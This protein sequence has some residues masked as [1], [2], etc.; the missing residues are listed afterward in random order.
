MAA[1]RDAVPADPAPDAAGAPD[2]P[3]ARDRPA[4]PLLRVRDLEAAYGGAIV[5]LHGVS[6]DVAA[7]SIVALLGANGAGKSTTLKAISRLLPASRGELTAGRIELRGEDIAR[8]A[9]DALVARGVSQVLEG[10]RCFAH[11]SVE[12]NLLVGGF[13]RHASRGRLREALARI[14]ELFPRLKERR[15]SLAGVTS[16]GEQQMVAIGRALMA[17]PTLVLLDEPSMGLA[18]L[19]VHEIFEAVGRLNREA[20]TTVVLAEQNATI[21]LQYAHAG[22]VLETGRVV[23]SGSAAELSARADVREFYLGRAGGEGGLLPEH[24]KRRAPFGGVAA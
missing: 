24:L 2:A 22:H 21:A 7:G 8:L 5:A 1:P 16:G 20:G 10:R 11:L 6:F 18:P 13:V 12:E 19:I 9:P 3:T 17:E 14:Y 15:R 23:A 4:P